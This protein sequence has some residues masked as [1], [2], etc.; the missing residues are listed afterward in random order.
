MT[1]LVQRPTVLLVDD[2]PLVREVT[3]RILEGAN[4]EVLAADGGPA[5][6][7]LAET[8]EGRIDLL[9]T[10]MAMPGMDGLEVAAQVR[11]LRPQVRVLYMSGYGETPETRREASNG[12]GRLVAKPFSRAQLVQALADSLSSEGPSVARQAGPAPDDSV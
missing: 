2:E 4:V 10:D 12:G 1:E 7:A 11:R 6:I 3:R 8:F 5:A 9:L